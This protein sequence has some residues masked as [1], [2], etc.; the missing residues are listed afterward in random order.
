MAGGRNWHAGA[1][2]VGSARAAREHLVEGDSAVDEEGE[3]HGE[4]REVGGAVADV[5]G[6]GDGGGR[7]RQGHEALHHAEDEHAAAQQLADGE[8]QPAVAWGARQGRAGFRRRRRK[9]EADLG[10][11]MADA[12]RE[13]MSGSELPKA[14][15]V[16][17][18]TFSLMPSIFDMEMRFGQL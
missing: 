5:L 6:A 2:A 16:I 18:A 13:R 3:R 11:L 1:G 10:P 7:R 17:P 4:A 9:E 15:N 12:E 8:L 14:R